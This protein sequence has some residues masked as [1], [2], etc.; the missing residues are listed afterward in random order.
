MKFTSLM[1]NIKRDP[2]K[3]Y[4]YL[5]RYTNLG[6]KTYSPFANQA[7]VDDFYQPINPQSTFEVPCLMIPTGKETIYLNQP[8]KQIESLY[9]H[10]DLIV[11]PIHPQIFQDS[12]IAG[13]SKLKQYPKG[14]PIIVSPTSSSRTVMV[15]KEIPHFIK[16]HYPKRISR[17]IRRLR[18]NTIQNCIEVSQDLQ[19]LSDF[20]YLPETIGIV[21][22][23][24]EENW[25]FIIREFTP[26]PHQIEKNFLIPLFAL[27]SQDV[28][29]LNDPS[30][31]FQLIH[32]L[33]EDPLTFVLNHIMKPIIQKWC[34][35]VTER[36]ILLEF[37]G[38]NT[39]LEMDEKFY[40]NRIVYR[41]LDV[42]VD[43]EIRKE[44][45]LHL[46][47]PE[48][49]LID[50]ERRQALYSL[51]Y[52]SFIGHHLFDYLASFLKKIY[53]IDVHLLQNH[54]KEYFNLCFPH[55]HLY[56]SNKV[57]YYSDEILPENKYK[58]IEMNKIPTW[59]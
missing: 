33:N 22:G 16:L 31:L 42:Y 23:T 2:I 47:F 53:G 45:G 8:N 43:R 46:N 28:N 24:K 3:S 27:Y 14:E 58:L 55:S 10:N 20:A 34:S 25:G 52:D 30:L 37:H 44:K 12:Q 35:A 36:G 48:S 40:P 18:K 56:F 49:Y 50:P 59:R 4:L 15:I 11:F 38:Q 32:Q 19:N 21:Y 5:E 39:L 54:C 57:F 29:A 6:S 7:D 13:I 51:N 17:F 41:D 26:R 9:I 1:E